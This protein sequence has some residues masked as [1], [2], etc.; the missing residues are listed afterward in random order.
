MIRVL[1]YLFTWLFFERDDAY[2]AGMARD[3]WKGWPED[4]ARDTSET[5]H[6]DTMS[7]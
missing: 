2:D 1:D 7:P 6:P 3:G 4:E 5:V